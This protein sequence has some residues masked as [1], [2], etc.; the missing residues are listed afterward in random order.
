MEGKDGEI[1]SFFQ[2]AKIALR[3]WM[4]ACI[5][6]LVSQYFL[7]LQSA[8]STPVES[9]MNVHQASFPWTYS[10]YIWAFHCRCLWC[11][12]TSRQSL[13]SCRQVNMIEP[14]GLAAAEIYCGCSAFFFSC[15]LFS[16][17]ATCIH[18]SNIKWCSPQVQSVLTHFLHLFHCPLK[19]KTRTKRTYWTPYFLLHRRFA[20][21]EIK[22]GE[23]KDV[24]LLQ[25]ARNLRPIPDSC[26]RP[27]APC[28]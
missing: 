2:G 13:S 22:L 16:Q 21:S 11:T 24:L 23:R 14:A 3:L 5:I 15:C 9:Y 12:S 17:T 1:F 7:P 8:C 20:R 4:H 10:T 26:R 18:C 6:Q 19:S 27:P 25:N 28:R